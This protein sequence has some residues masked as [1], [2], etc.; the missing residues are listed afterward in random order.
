MFNKNNILKKN[1]EFQKILNQKKQIV[2]TNLIIYF[3]PSETLKVGIAIPKQFAKAVERN[4][5]KNQIKAILRSIP[6]IE[7]VNLRCVLIARKSFMRLDFAKKQESVVRLFE[8][9]RKNGKVKEI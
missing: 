5:Y 2:E 6:W 1:W 4:H 8:R 7:E 3:L 9:F